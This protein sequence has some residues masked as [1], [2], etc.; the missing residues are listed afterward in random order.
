M[1]LKKWLKSAGLINIV[2]GL[3]MFLISREMIVPVL[4]LVASGFYYQTY[5]DRENAFQNKWSLIILGIINLFC[6]F[7]SGVIVL[8]IVNLIKPNESYEYLTNK[9]KNKINVLLQLGVVLV[10]L[11]GIMIATNQSIIIPDLFKILGLCLL[12]IIFF[13]LSYLSKK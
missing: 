13:F 6:N 1:K 7:I 2:I 3:I 5:F 8:E 4:F 12:S 10:L 9:K 11:S